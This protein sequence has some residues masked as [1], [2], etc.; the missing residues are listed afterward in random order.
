MINFKE[1]S[2]GHDGQRVIDKL[3]FTVDSGDFVALIGAN[4]TG[5]ST[6][7]KSLTGILAPL[8]GKITFNIQTER[9]NPFNDIG[10]SPQ[11][12]LLDWYMNVYDNV[13]AGPLLVGF[14]RKKAQQLVKQT[15]E[16]M[17]LTALKTAPVDHISG[18]QQQRVQLA[19][20]LA[21]KPQ[22]YLLDEPTTGLDVETAEA[23]FTYLKKQSEQGA[24]VLVSSHDLT[25]LEN[26][27]TKLI[28]LDAGKQKYFGTLADYLN[29]ERSLREWYLQERGENESTEF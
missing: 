5:K 22:I 4:G 28:F 13:L 25:L 21:K 6:L 14:P 8:S 29:D 9:I 16:L 20:E 26:Y 24:L 19:R 18:G 7:I 2:L 27:A 12:Q 23:L 15:L 17:G 1:T 11:S 10:I 3:N